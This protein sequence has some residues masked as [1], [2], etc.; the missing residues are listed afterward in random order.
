M[1]ARP[2]HPQPCQNRPPFGTVLLPF[3][4]VVSGSG[5]GFVHVRAPQLSRSKRTSRATQGCVQWH[6]GAKLVK[7]AGANDVA[8]GI[9]GR[10]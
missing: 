6:N 4:T 8:Y 7:L 9:A 3:I 1:A 2:G 10:Q 5:N